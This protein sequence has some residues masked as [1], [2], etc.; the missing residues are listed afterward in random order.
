M[1]VSPNGNI[2]RVSNGFYCFYGSLLYKKDDHNL[3]T[4][5]WVFV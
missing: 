3:L 4:N 1:E 5:G 2:Y